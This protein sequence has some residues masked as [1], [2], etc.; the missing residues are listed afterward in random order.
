MDI[1]DFGTTG[2]K[3][4]ALG[5]GTGHL[6]DD[7][8]SEKDAERLLNTAADMGISLFDT[9]R[10]YDRSE[11][12][13]GK[14]LSHRRGEVILSTKVGYGIEGLAD[15]TYDCVLAGVRR[16][17]QLMKT[18]YLDIVHLHSCPVEVLRQG[19]VVDALLQS[20]EEGFVRVAAYSG[21]NE[22]LLFALESSRFRSLQCSINI[23]DQRTLDGPL[24]RAKE[25]GMGI[26]AK[27]PVANAP[28]RYAECPVGHYAEEYWKRW[29]AMGLHIE[30]PWQELALRFAAYTWGVDSC[31]VGTTSLAHLQ[32]NIR[33]INNGKLPQPVI[34]ELRNSFR[35][36]DDNWIGQV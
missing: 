7:S 25:R 27:R 28:W 19:A 8:L 24:P 6:G 10:G 9:A 20:V 22:H 26:I 30:M 34:D 36:H 16:A 4:S 3:V 17:R 12:R 15:W 11:E 14:Y 23:C 13:I 1:R 31:I 35:M 32:Q 29:K 5:L 33:F 2:I 21:E 18:D